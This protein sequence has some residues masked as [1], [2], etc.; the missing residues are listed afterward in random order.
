MAR[1][2]GRG[3]SGAPRGRWHAIL[4]AMGQAPAGNA[5][6]LTPRPAEYPG[7][8]AAGGAPPEVPDFDDP[9]HRAFTQG[10]TRH[11][12]EVAQGSDVWQ[13]WGG[14]YHRRL[15]EIY[16]FLVAPGLRVLE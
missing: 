7:Q 4:A 13:G 12:D 6:R 8:E 1:G 5:E 11:W 9:A 16:R 15:A 10:R 2:Q 14:A 3:G